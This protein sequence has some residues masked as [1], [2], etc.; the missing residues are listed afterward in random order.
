M[1][2]DFD[3]SLVVLFPDLPTTLSLLTPV[4]EVIDA[5]SEFCILFEVGVFDLYLASCIL[6][7]WVAALDVPLGV[8]IVDP[9]PVPEDG[10]AFVVAVEPAALPPALAAGADVVLVFFSNS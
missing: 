8:V 5:L 6:V 1:F 7:G 9:L 3:V 2:L 4:F 10:A